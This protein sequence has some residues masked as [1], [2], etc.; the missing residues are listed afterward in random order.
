ML[1]R[2]WECSK[3]VWNHLIGSGLL[4]HFWEFPV[5]PRWFPSFVYSN[6]LISILLENFKIT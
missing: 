1:L 4:Q 3:Y 6:F 5:S 2:G